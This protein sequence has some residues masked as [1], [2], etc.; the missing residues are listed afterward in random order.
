M[1]SQIPSLEFGIFFILEFV[2]LNWNLGFEKF[3]I[4]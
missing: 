2:F 3:G 1:K 4:C